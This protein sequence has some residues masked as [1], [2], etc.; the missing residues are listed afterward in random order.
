MKEFPYNNWF[1]QVT[2]K[3]RKLIDDWRIHKLGYSSSI[4]NLTSYINYK[5]ESSIYGSRWWRRVGLRGESE[6]VQISTIDFTIY[7]LGEK[8]SKTDDY[9]YL[10][11]L[12]KKLKIS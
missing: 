9:N 8:M 2:D 6:L 1:I 4:D 11:D 3:N 5:G 7:V 10:V 12:L